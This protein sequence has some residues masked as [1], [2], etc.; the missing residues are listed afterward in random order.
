MGA[1]PSIPAASRSS[2][3]NNSDV[4]DFRQIV[5]EALKQ[6][7]HDFADRKD[8]ITIQQTSTTPEQLEI[9]A[10]SSEIRRIESLIAS[11]ASICQVL[12]NEIEDEVAA[13]DP[14][15]RAFDGIFSSD[16]TELNCLVKP[17][18]ILRITA[19]AVC[20]MLE[21]KPR[22]VQVNENCCEDFWQPFKKMC[23]ENCQQEDFLNV[24]KNYDK[25]NIPN[26]VIKKIREQYITDPNFT[27]QIV[28]PVSKFGAS[29]C[30]WV[31]AM[32]AYALVSKRVQVKIDRIK[33][34]EKNMELQIELLQG[35][36]K[37]M[38]AAEN[39][40]ANFEIS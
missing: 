37:E 6:I 32:Y 4:L 40:L 19:E 11:E 13:C 7:V 34:S 38:K 39:N 33:A 26:H 1:T 31:H 10:K 2:F 17:P 36:Q 12:K 28:R 29:L 27:P 25:N 14:P 16:L 24:F 35:K 22:T 18:E 15:Y 5:D 9:M 30:Q 8:K 23:C 3:C 21:I 20:I